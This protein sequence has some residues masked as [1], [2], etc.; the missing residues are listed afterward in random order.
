[1]ARIKLKTRVLSKYYLATPVFMLVE[2]LAGMDLRVSIPWGGELLTY[3]YMAVCFVLGGFILKNPG[4]LNLFA[5]FESSVN[6]F[7]LVLSVYLPI[8]AVTGSPGEAGAFNFG[9]VELIHFVIVGSVLLYVFY[10]NPLM[11]KKA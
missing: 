8:I 10:S 2:W 5:L 7:L 6:L 1:M 4:Y 3:L 11:K 9:I